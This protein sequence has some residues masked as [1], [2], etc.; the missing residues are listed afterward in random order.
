MK[1]TIILLLDSL[2]L[3]GAQDADKFRGETAEG[4]IFNDVGS[5]TL[6]HI[7]QECFEG[8]AQEG[9][10]GPLYIPNLNRL[11]FGHACFES[12]GLFPAGLDESVN[13]VAAYGYAKELSTGKDTTSGHWEIC[14]VPVEF[15]CGICLP[16]HVP[17]HKVHRVFPNQ[18]SLHDRLSER[19]NLLK[20]RQWVFLLP[21]ALH[22][23]LQE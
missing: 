10:S 7:A 17:V 5:N 12:S 2:G 15:E 4:K 18:N 11:G 6:G 14:G 9:R 13:P 19:L 22:P 20:Y 16:V 8:R 23:T 21:Y 3:G 1:R